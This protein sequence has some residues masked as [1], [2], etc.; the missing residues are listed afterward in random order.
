LVSIHHCEGLCDSKVCQPKAHTR[1]CH[2]PP[3]VASGH[4]GDSFI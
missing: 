4:P 1:D 3:T 2:S